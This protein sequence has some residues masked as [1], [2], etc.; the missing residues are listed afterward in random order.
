MSKNTDWL[1]RT[2]IDR[3]ELE[4]RMERTIEEIL[5]SAALCAEAND[6]FR[7]APELKA[8]SEEKI[9]ESGTWY[10]KAQ[11]RAFPPLQEATIDCPLTT[12]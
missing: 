4:D 7:L 9:K 5:E 3:R 10:Q 6:L 11:L 8:Q 2:Y 1:G 12:V